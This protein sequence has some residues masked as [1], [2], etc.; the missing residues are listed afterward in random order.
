MEFEKKYFYNV[1]KIYYERDAN[2]KKS[3]W[4]LM[5]AS[6]TFVNRSHP[7]VRF[8]D[9][10][11]MSMGRTGYELAVFYFFYRAFWEEMKEFKRGK[12]FWIDSAQDA[13]S[14][15]VLFEWLC[16]KRNYFQ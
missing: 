16:I 14:L 5:E 2:Q 12:G 6:E 3:G 7:D 11:K 4:N 10:E 8:K 15:Q 1:A 13:H 9:S